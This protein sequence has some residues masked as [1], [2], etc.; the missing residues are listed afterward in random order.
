MAAIAS[1]QP[2]PGRNPYDL[3]S[4]RASHSGSNA[5]L[6]LACWARSRSTGTVA[7]NCTSCRSGLGWRLEVDRVGDLLVAGGLDLGWERHAPAAGWGAAGCQLAVLD[8]VVDGVG[9]DAEPLGDAGHAQLAWREGCGCGHA[10]D[11]AQPAHGLDVEGPS[12]A[13]R[14]AGLVE[15]VGQLGV[16]ASGSQTS[17]QL[18]GASRSAAQLHRG[19]AAGG[20]QFLG[21]A[22]VPADADAQLGPV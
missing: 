9:G 11:V 15:F 4:N 1:W 17:Q 3:G 22:R 7:S 19:G 14:V 6:T 5:F 20:E 18:H 2:R 10:V 13:G 8:P 12:R 16:A 21:G